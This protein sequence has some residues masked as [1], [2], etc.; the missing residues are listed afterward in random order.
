MLAFALF[1]LI[2]EKK[3]LKQQLDEIFGMCFGGRYCI[4][5]MSIFSIFTGL[6]YNEFFSM[7]TVI[8]GRTHARVRVRV[9]E[10]AAGSCRG[11][12]AQCMGLLSR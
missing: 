12:L 1:L 4:L 10:G 3:F 2:N 8:F 11:Q 6:I 9:W 5:L 7:P